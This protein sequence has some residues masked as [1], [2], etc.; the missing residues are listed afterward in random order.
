[1]LNVLR[2]VGSLTFTLFDKKNEFI[3][4]KYLQIEALYE[5]AI[6]LQSKAVE[7]VRQDEGLII[8]SDIDYSSYV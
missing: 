1:M 7:E 6:M 3:R 4:Y 8:P 2:R 5:H